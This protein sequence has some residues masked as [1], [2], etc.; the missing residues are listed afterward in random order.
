MCTNDCCGPTYAP[1]FVRRFL[2]CKFNIACINH[3]A[4]YDEGILTRKECDEIFLSEMLEIS[5]N[6]WDSLVA[7][8]YYC[9]VRLFGYSQYNRSNYV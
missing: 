9:S 6:K 7:Y 8:I 4:N 3:D 2:S 1:K 5:F